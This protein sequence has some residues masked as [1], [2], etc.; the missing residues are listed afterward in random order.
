MS[1]CVSGVLLIRFP[2][3]FVVFKSIRCCCVFL[4]CVQVCLFVRRRF[5]RDWRCTMVGC[6]KVLP[7]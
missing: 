7:R 2:Y 1:G 5:I 4:P 6:G 3:D